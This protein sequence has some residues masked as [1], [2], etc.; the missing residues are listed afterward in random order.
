MK[1]RIG[2]ASAVDTLVGKFSLNR[3]PGKVSWKKVAEHYNPTPDVIQA[4]TGNPFF[5]LDTP[6]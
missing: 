5:V 2:Q 1:V 4:S 6:F 3:M